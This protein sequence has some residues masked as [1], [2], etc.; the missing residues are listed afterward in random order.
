MLQILVLILKSQKTKQNKV[1]I[2]VLKPI[3]R[4]M[5]ENNTIQT[6]SISIW[7][8][9]NNNANIVRTFH[10]TIRHMEQQN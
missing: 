3:C 8:A 2:Y 10:P 6:T 5:E 7:F 4:I 9:R 1:Q